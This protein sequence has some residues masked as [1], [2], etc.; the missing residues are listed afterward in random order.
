MS[1]WWRLLAEPR[2]PWTEGR[3]N[4]QPG[5][6]LSER[7]QAEGTQRRPQRCFYFFSFFSL[8]REVVSREGDVT[9]ACAFTHRE[10]RLRSVPVV[11]LSSDTSRPQLLR[12][13][14][15]IIPWFGAETQ[16]LR[17]VPA[18]FSEESAPPGRFSGSLRWVP[19]NSSK[20]SFTRTLRALYALKPG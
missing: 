20:S 6:G 14:G 8:C 9:G 19:R 1:T 11:F 10:K 3:S 15:R 2:S 16:L 13:S 12:S 4:T 17:L 7:P 18:D 5:I